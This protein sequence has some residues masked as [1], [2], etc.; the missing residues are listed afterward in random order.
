MKSLVAMKRRISS[1]DQLFYFV[2]TKTT[3][4]WRYFR[5]SFALNIYQKVLLPTLIRIIIQLVSKKETTCFCDKKNFKNALV[6][7]SKQKEEAQR[8]C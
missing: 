4:E 7:L 2:S 5:S 3:L 8:R 1:R 6:G